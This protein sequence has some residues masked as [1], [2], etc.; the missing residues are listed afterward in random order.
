MGVK[1]I[2]TQ[3]K[4]EKRDKSIT[5]AVNKIFKN[6]PPKVKYVGSDGS[7]SARRARRAGGG[8][9][10][11]ARRS[12]RRAAEQTR[13]LNLSAYAELLRSDIRLQKV[14]IITEVMGF[15][16]AEDKA[17]WPIY[18]DY[19]ARDGEARRRARRAHRRLRASTTSS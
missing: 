10:A 14:A 15:T 4:P 6:Y 3:A 12:P 1:E 5:N 17:F 19:D 18:R 8:L 2:D 13:T 7:T 9:P 16:E 11:A